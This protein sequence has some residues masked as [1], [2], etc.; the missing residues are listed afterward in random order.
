M[1]IC[2]DNSNSSKNSNTK[3]QAQNLFICVLYVRCV[4]A[5]PKRVSY[6]S[7]VSY[8]VASSKRRLRYGQFGKNTKSE[9]HKMR[10]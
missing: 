9:K 1:T 7:I 5:S 4:P 6:C 10:K 3:R 8:R 2:Y